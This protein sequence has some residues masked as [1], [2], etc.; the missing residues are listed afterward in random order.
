[1]TATLSG[2]GADGNAGIR[3]PRRWLAGRSDPVARMVA[4][5]LGL[6]PA[7]T[8]H[9][10]RNCFDEAA[11]FIKALHQL[12]DHARLCRLIAP[13][14]AA[15]A[16]AQPPALTAELFLEEAKAD[17]AEDVA[18]VQLLNTMTPEHKRAYLRRAYAAIAA[19][20]K[21]CRALEASLVPA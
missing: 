10:L 6:S 11:L 1:M 15:L 13:I 12:G 20:Q 18:E 21:V 8:E 17:A 7:S 9:R 16:E 19:S 2:S 14:D 3:R 4:P 5:Q